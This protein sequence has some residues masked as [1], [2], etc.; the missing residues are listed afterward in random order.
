MLCVGVAVARIAEAP[1]TD[2]QPVCIFTD[3]VLRVD[4]L[5]PGREKEVTKYDVLD[6]TVGGGW[7]GARRRVTWS[8]DWGG[9]KRTTGG[10]N[11]VHSP[12]GPPSMSRSLSKIRCGRGSA[13]MPLLTT[14]DRSTDWPEP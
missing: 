4:G 8:H 7:F 9:G 1:T 13:K 2:I 12:V 11:G 14:V 10:A 5:I 3:E 6:V